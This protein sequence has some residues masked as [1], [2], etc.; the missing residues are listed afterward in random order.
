MLDLTEAQ[1]AEVAKILVSQREQIRKLWND[2]TVAPEYRIGAMRAINYETEDRIRALLNDEQ[3]TKY[4]A[5]H[6]D[7]APPASQEETLNHWLNAAKPK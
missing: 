5:P 1:Q 3:K 4:R 6:S 2:Q 7:R